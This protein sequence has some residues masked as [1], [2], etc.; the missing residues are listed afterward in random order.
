MDFV[1]PALS[2]NAIEVE[3]FVDVPISIISNAALRAHLGLATKDPCVYHFDWLVESF[4]SPGGGAG[5][6]LDGP[7]DEFNEMFN[8]NVGHIIKKVFSIGGGKRHRR[9]HKRK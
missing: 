7:E 5:E 1:V 4:S 2:P 6:N 9:K 8:M 3:P